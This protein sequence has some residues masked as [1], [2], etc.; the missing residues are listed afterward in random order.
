MTHNS[1]E[2]RNITHKTVKK[3]C[4]IHI[5]CQETGCTAYLL[6]SVSVFKLK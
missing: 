4:N 5:K 6:N 3:K 2:S 1:L